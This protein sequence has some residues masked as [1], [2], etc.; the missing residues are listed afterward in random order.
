MIQNLWSMGDRPRREVSITLYFKQK[1]VQ[2]CGLPNKSVTWQQ[3]YL[4]S[5][6]Q[7]AVK[8]LGSCEFRS[9]IIFDCYIPLAWVVSTRLLCAGFLDTQGLTASREQPPWHTVRR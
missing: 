3:E 7:A 8:A 9:R 4:F 1:S 5:P 6:S 2:F